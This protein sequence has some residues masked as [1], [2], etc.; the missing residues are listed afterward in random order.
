MYSQAQMRKL[1][2]LTWV[3]ASVDLSDCRFTLRVFLNGG[4]GIR[5]DTGVSKV[6][7][8]HRLN[9][10][11]KTKRNPRH[12]FNDLGIFEGVLSRSKLGRKYRKYDSLYRKRKMCMDQVTPALIEGTRHRRTRKNMMETMSKRNYVS[13]IREPIG[14]DT[15]PKR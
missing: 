11:M 5:T 10:T 3:R 6:S 7:R 8:E 4:L 9:S 12:G 1:L 15:S 2:H 13:G 14:G